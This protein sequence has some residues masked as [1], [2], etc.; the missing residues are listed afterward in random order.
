MYITP[1][2]RGREDVYI[3]PVVRG[4]E[5]VYITPVVRG[6]EDV[7]ITPVVRGR[8]GGSCFLNSPSSIADHIYNDIFMKP[9]PIT[10]CNSSCSYNILHVTK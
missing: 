8:E 9:F 7:Y 1:V 3:T 6:R 2:V 4:R 5:D 10:S